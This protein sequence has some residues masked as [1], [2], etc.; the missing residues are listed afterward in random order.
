MPSLLHWVL[1]P[2]LLVLPAAARA[3]SVDFDARSL[4]LPWEFSPTVLLLTLLA[5]GVYAN[6]LR[7]RRRRGERSGAVRAV[8]YFSGVLLIYLV[9][10]TRVDYWAQHMFYIH[11]LQHLVLHHMGPFLVA[12]SVPQRVL[13]AGIPDRAWASVVG[14]ILRRGPIPVVVRVLMDPILAPVL[15]VF[16]I[17]FWLIPAVHFRAMLGLP[18]YNVMNWSMVIDG[19]PFWWLV[20]NP[21]P[22]PPA[23][24]GYGARIL[25]LAAVV[26][27]QIL[28]GAYIG[29]SRHDLFSV[30]DICG[31]IYALG[32]VTDQQIGG[33]LIWI[34]GSM[35][36]VL[37]ALLV[38]AHMAG[39]RRD[40]GV[41]SGARVAAQMP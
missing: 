28:I 19:L 37:G 26:P 17:A 16:G 3:A 5:L 36:S 27:P 20:L 11:R 23:R 7:A 41:A 2:A 25:M 14:P 34:P 9:L 35:M 33:L 15:F 18:F 29:L 31:R 12:L 8:A 38:L 1:L 21:A 40:G 6:G 22:K 24:V 39:H 30:Y 32:A 10:Q 4:L 13:R